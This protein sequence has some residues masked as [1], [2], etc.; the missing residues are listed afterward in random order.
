MTRVLVALDESPVS[1]R[2][3]R[4]AVPLFS[5]HDAEFLVINVASVQMPWLPLPGLGAV[6]W[7]EADFDRSLAG[8]E[9]HDLEKIARNAGI[10]DAELLTEVGDPV[11]CICAAAEQHDVDVI[12]VGSHDKGFVLRLI[13]LSVSAGVV[14]ATHRPVLVVSA[15][16]PDA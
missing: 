15:S 14:R 8:L 16:S 12:V 10:E 9:E 3:A 11:E 4:E 7:L 5:G 2:A 1:L 6:S 13:Q